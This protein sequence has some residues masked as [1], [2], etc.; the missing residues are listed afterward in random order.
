MLAWAVQPDGLRTLRPITD[1]REWCGVLRCAAGERRRD[2]D[3]G[4][5][6]DGARRDG[7]ARRRALSRRHPGQ[8][9]RRLFRCA[10]LRAARDL[11]RPRAAVRA[12]ASASVRCARHSCRRTRR[13][14]AATRPAAATCGARPISRDCSPVI[15]LSDAILAAHRAAARNV[16]HRGA[17]GLS[18]HLRGTNQPHVT[19]VI[20]VPPS[21]DEHTFEQVLEQLAPLP[22]GRE[23]ARG[24][25]ACAL[26]VAVWIDGAPH[27]RADAQRAARA[28]RPRARRH[29]VVLGTHGVLPPRGIA[30][31]AARHRTPSGARRASRACCSRSRRSPRSDDVHDVVGRVQERAQRIIQNE[32]QLESKA[33]IGFAMTLSEV[34]QNIIEHAGQGG[35]VAVQSY[36]WT[37]A[38]RAPRRRDR[39]MRRRAW[40]PE[41]ARVR[42]RA[43]ADRRAGTTPPRSRRR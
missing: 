21:L 8:A 16:G 9:R 39:G 4:A 40:V 38:A 5:R 19:Q 22:A 25:A 13:S 2:A 1:V 12:L 15:T 43:P 6:P 35:W 32:L 33:I 3:A 20:T 37:R 23:A 29:G 30:L 34:C 18:D 14:M 41:I 17:S 26:G 10:R 36:R 31:R 24:R 27:A 28:R 7:A 11:Q 42:T